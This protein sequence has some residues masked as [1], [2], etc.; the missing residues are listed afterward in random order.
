MVTEAVTAACRS[1][2]LAGDEVYGRS[3]KLRAACEDA[4]K[5]YVSRSR[6]T[7]RSPPPRAARRPSPPWPGSFPARC[8]ETRSCGRGCKG[9][10]DYEWALAAT[11]S[12]RHWLLIRRKISD[13]ADLA[14]FYCHAP[15]PVSLAILI[16]VA[17]KRWPVEECFQQGKGRPALTSTSSASGTPS[18]AT[19]CCP[20][21]PS[22]CSPSRPPGHPAP[23]YPGPPRRAPAA[24]AA[25][26]RHHRPAG[27]LARHRQAPRPPRRKTTPRHRPD[28]RHRAR[29][30]PAVRRHP[31]ARP[32]AAPGASGDDAT[33]HAPDGTTTRHNSRQRQHDPRD[34]PGRSHHKPGLWCPGKRSASPDG[35]AG[36]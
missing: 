27:T 24:A 33:R 31:C 5:G 3:S 25:R 18:T 8:W 32:S 23:P 29:S 2:G 22:R 16:K 28:P 11:S 30:P 10:R 7:S 36:T 21:A 34:L 1:A 20:C 14:F 19:P 35:R 26:R 17:G 13:P 9:H 12:P 6:S 15:G 4:G